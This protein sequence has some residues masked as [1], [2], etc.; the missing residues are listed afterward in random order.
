MASYFYLYLLGVT[1]ISG[2]SGLCNVTSSLCGAY[3]P[4]DI[5]IGILSS[6][7]W[8][9]STFSSSNRPYTQCEEF[10]LIS[11]VQSLAVIQT[12]ETINNSSFL[13]GIRLGYR[14]CDSCVS[15]SKALHCVAHMLA[16]NGSLPVLSDY[17]HYDA[18]VKAFL[19]E[20]FSELSIAVSKMLSLY[21]IPQISCTASAPILSDKLRYPSFLRVIPSDI[22]QTQAI[23]KLMRHFSWDWVGVLT[24]DDDYGKAVLENFLLAAEKVKVCVDFKE[25]LP[26]I[27]A[28]EETVKKAADLIRSSTAKVVL[29]ILRP[30]QLQMLFKEMIRTN[31]I[32]TWIASDSWSMT[33]SLMKIKDINKVGDILGFTFVTGEI[34]GFK[35]YLQ[36]LQPSA[37][38][39]NDFITEYKQLRDECP[40]GSNSDN[41]HPS[42]CEIENDLLDSVNLKAAHSQR[43]AVYAVAHAIKKILECNETACPGDT[44]FPLDKL[45]AILHDINFTLDNKTY[46]FTDDG[47]LDD[48][49]DLIMWTKADNRR[50]PSVVG[51]FLINKKD[52]EVFD[53]D[54]Q[55]LNNTVA[56]NTLCCNHFNHRKHLSSHL[57]D[58][59]KV[60]KDLSPWHMEEY[61][62][63]C[64]KCP[65]GTTSLENSTQ[66]K[67]WK[68]WYLKWSDPHP[69]V[70]INGTGIGI[71]L[72]IF[73]FV[74][75]IL[76]KHNPI[77][78][79]T[80]IFSCIMKFGLLVSFIGVIIFLGRPSS[81]QCMAQQA[82]YGLGFTLC[83]SCILTKAFRT[84]IAYMACDP[85]TQ[86]RLRKID[87]PFVIIGLLTGFQCV[88]FILWFVL[89]KPGT[90]MMISKSQPLTMNH[91]CTQGPSM[92]GFGVMHTYIAILAAVCFL[93]AFKARDNETDAIVFSMLIHLFA[94][95]CFIPVFIT[96]NDQRPIIQISAIMVS[97]YGVIFCHFTPKWF[98]IISEKMEQKNSVK[99]K[100]RQSTDSVLDSAIG[101]LSTQGS[102]D[103]LPVS[104]PGSSTLSDSTDDGLSSQDHGLNSGNSEYSETLQS[105][106]A[107][108]RHSVADDEM[109][110]LDRTADLEESIPTSSTAST[111]SNFRDVSM[112]FRINRLKRSCLE[113]TA[114]AQAAI[115]NTAQISAAD[116]E[117]PNWCQ[118]NVSIGRQRT[119]SF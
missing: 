21:M 91:L 29:L 89:D 110:D 66:C 30:F 17:T 107:S 10:N 59:V 111:V 92:I 8:K 14:M 119:R 18:P 11:F 82:M 61:Q 69:I 57:G 19:G 4:G 84:F 118:D 42:A 106:S 115:R 67:E 31:T 96:Q 79:D 74:F 71:L 108:E 63:T 49:Y 114:T 109:S 13:P 45:V 35:D 95:L 40:M 62:E 117:M 23:A 22:Y 53:Q 43:V 1:L 48:G 28:S 76:K 34:P 20:R 60:F 24:L 9:L 97:N 105:T 80:L 70:V 6:V 2:R 101:S 52:V 5:V 73:S 27:D 83:V 36:N 38:G 37:G 39:W 88:I 94:W 46:S 113:D 56:V 93:L 15:S 25:V 75:F 65:N 51:K 7:H 16:V 112:S 44:N 99:N 41:T 90:E 33:G 116:S 47:D 50:I 81:Y 86:H 103:S 77:I 87:K 72:L 58:P 54:L 104:I 3:L 78:K 68:V 102:M 64:K 100:N 55:W 12:I 26:T 32:R 85:H 98:K